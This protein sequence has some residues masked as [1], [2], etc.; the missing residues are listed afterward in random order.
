MLKN[1]GR[2]S[3]SILTMHGRVTFERTMM[4]GIDKA[5]TEALKKITGESSLFPLVL[6]TS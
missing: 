1:Q 2:Y 6:M 3:K 5:N 4:I